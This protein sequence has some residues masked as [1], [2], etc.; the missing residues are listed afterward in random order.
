[1]KLAPPQSSQSSFRIVSLDASVDSGSGLSRGVSGPTYSPPRMFDPPPPFFLAIFTPQ[2]KR[3]SLSLF[4]RRPS[5]S[6]SW[7]PCVIPLHGFREIVLEYNPSPAS[8]LRNRLVNCPGTRVLTF[9]SSFCFL[10]FTTW[11][12]EKV[13][14]PFS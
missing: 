3:W 8:T 2:P 1:M 5:T 10:F 13:I 14:S 6:N 7:R 4:P 9:P 11:L 12:P